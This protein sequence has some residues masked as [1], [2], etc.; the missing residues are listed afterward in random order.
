VLYQ[1]FVIVIW[2]CC[3]SAA[4][5]KATKGDFLPAFTAQQRQLLNGS[6]D[7]IAANCFTAKWVSARPGSD[8]G[9]RESKTD[10]SGK[11][12]GAATG[13]PWINVVP[14]SQAKMLRYLTQRYSGKAVPAVQAVLPARLPQV[15][16]SSAAADQQA[17]KPSGAAGSA[18]TRSLKG[19]A[20][21]QQLPVTQQPAILISSSGV[22]VPGEDKQSLPGVLNDS[23]RIEYYRS[24]LNSVCEAAADGVRVIGWYAWSFM[25]GFEWTDGYTRKFGLVH[26]KYDGPQGTPAAV[27]AA[28]KSLQRAP[29]QSALWLSKHFFK[30]SA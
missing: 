9:W 26:V 24:Y 17:L 15:G 4:T 19:Q 30:Q 16:Q 5:L 3:A 23:A 8:L 2:Q 6:L 22:Q 29:K 13:V 12:I 7:F 27:A 1:P 28:G 11:L 20:A 10:G 18:S 21:Q 14:W 25:D